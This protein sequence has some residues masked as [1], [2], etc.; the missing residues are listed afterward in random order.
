VLDKRSLLSLHSLASRSIWIELV[1][2]GWNMIG[3]AQGQTGWLKSAL[4]K[5]FVPYA[6]LNP[7]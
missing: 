6:I 5:S 1:L 7:V 2:S 3:F 4:T